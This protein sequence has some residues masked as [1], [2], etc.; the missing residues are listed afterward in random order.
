VGRGA[1]RPCG[2][3]AFSALA[4]APVDALSSGTRGFVS[5][6]WASEP[7]EAYV[8]NDLDEFLCDH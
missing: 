4:S 2:A 5:V 7:D 6:S 3:G 1:V 8:A